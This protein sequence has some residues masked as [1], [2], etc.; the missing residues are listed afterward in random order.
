MKK[1]TIDLAIQKDELK[2]IKNFLLSKKTPVHIEEIA[3][4]IGLKRTKHL[5][6]QKIKVYDRKYKY[7]VQDL[8]YMNLEEMKFRL[9]KNNELVFSGEIVF[10]IVNKKYSPTLCYS[11]I[12]V[13][14]EGEGEFRKIINMLKKKKVSLEFPVA[15]DDGEE[16]PFYDGKDP[17]ENEPPLPSKYLQKLREN[18]E[19]L[20]LDSKDFLNW[21]EYWIYKTQLVK[22]K[23]KDEV[24]IVRELEKRK[25]SITTREIKDSVL[26]IE[27]EKHSEKLILFSIN[28]HLSEHQS[29]VCVDYEDWGKWNLK[30]FFENI[31][32]TEL[33]FKKAKKVDSF[34]KKPKEVESL[35]KD[36]LKKAKKFYS[37][38][39]NPL[40]LREIVS[41]ALKLT[42]RELNLIGNRREIT[43]SSG[44]GES[45]KVW[46]FPY[47]R[48]LIGLRKYYKV[49]QIVPGTA[50][51]LKVENGEFILEPKVGK[52][53]LKVLVFDYDEEEKRFIEKANTT[54]YYE[55]FPYFQLNYGELDEL[56]EISEGR[57]V[58]STLRHIFYEFGEDSGEYKEFH[59]LRA[60][61]LLN[62]LYNISLQDTVKLLL[63]NSEFFDSEEKPGIF[64]LDTEKMRVREEEERIA[65]LEKEL[66]EKK[67]KLEKKLL[68]HVPKDT[69]KEAQESLPRDDIERQKEKIARRLQ[70][71]REKGVI[72]TIHEKVPL[73]KKDKLEAKKSEEKPETHVEKVV[74]KEIEKEA[75][76]KE[77]KVVK[78]EKK[79]VEKRAPKAKKPPV[80]KQPKVEFVEPVK[81]EKEEKKKR[82]KKEKAKVSTPKKKSARRILEEELEMK[83]AEKEAMEALKEE[84]EIEVKSKKKHIDEE[85]TVVYSDKKKKT[86]GGVLGDKLKEILEKKKK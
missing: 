62:I 73:K 69:K 56:Y 48:Y 42:K 5:R 3:R 25:D 61:H 7:N 80:K 2:G 8:I 44:S 34:E 35:A 45:Y 29:F 51:S 71:I 18:L 58:L 65:L 74:V 47:E 10:R 28:Y 50:L 72:E 86:G 70:K 9:S 26:K 52:K 4:F 79:T 49:N 85:T 83:E 21:G 32:K 12:E 20:L 11:L 82:K 24:K 22:V 53:P 16:A 68:K 38:E 15:G 27:D 1:D 75:E 55:L 43:I 81:E 84:I 40:L 67:E 63:G 37:T 33:V 66:K 19:K 17:R 13:D 60:F 46:V 54:V 41:G 14:Y 39:S 6:Q 31:K 78:T 76:K 64:I 36:F 23:G 77:T 57:T 30:E 59:Y